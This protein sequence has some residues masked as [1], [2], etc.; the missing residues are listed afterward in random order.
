MKELQIKCNKISMSDLKM[1]HMQ[2]PNFGSY[3]KKT[4][5]EGLVSFV[6]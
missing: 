6:L 3:K 4:F 1:L 5:L 2:L